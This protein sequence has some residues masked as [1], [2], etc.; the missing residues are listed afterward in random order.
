M[1]SIDRIARRWWDVIPEAERE[2]I[3]AAVPEGLTLAISPGH[4]AK[5]GTMSVGLRD[6]RGYS[7]GPKVRGRLSAPLCWA[8]LREVRQRVTTD[9][10]GYVT[11]WEK[12]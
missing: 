2:R 12:A 7:A 1:V 5:P 10:E 3:D 9:A 6:D 4:R 8:A 11:E